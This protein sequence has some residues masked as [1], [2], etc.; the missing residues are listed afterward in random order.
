MVTMKTRR[1][2]SRLHR[3]LIEAAIR[4]A[5]RKTSGEIVVI[6]HHKPVADAVAFARDEFLRRGLQETRERNAV[7]ILVAPE[8]QSFALVGDQGVHEKCGE[9]FWRE[10]AS[11]MQEHFRAGNYTAALLEGIE[12]AGTLLAGHFPRKPDDSNE[13]SDRVIER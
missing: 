11:A 13:L 9:D 4:D 8:S 6:I 12:R 5:E 1:F 10:L 2:T 3:Q 7:L